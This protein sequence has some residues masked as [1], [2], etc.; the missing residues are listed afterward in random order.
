M[1]LNRRQFIQASAATAAA[2]ALP[3]EPG[4]PSGARAPARRGGARHRLGLEQSTTWDPNGLEELA[5][6]S[7]QAEQGDRFRQIEYRA[8]RVL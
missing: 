7:K 1:A 2:T 3:G 6:P 8:V 5:G 4:R